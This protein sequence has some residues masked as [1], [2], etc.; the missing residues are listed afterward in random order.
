MEISRRHLQDTERA[1]LRDILLVGGISDA[2]V[3]ELERIKDQMVEMSGGAAKR[4]SI[5]V[6]TAE[7]QERAAEILH[8]DC[9]LAEL[10]EHA[11]PDAAEMQRQVDGLTRNQRRVLNKRMRKAAKK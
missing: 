1:G 3:Q 9:R 4:N 7:S 5:Q 6:H 8:A 2:E 10:A 11:L